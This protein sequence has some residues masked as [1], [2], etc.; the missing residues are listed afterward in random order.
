[1]RTERRIDQHRE[2][3]I[4]VAIR[5]HRF[6]GYDY[7]KSYLVDMNIASLTIDRVLSTAPSR[8]VL[9]NPALQQKT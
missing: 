5:L 9:S 7:A 1:M 8:K 6:Y 2:M 3:L 4:E